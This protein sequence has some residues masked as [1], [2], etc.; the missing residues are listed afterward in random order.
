MGTSFRF[1]H[2]VGYSV[3]LFRYISIYV[4][5][6]IITAKIIRRCRRK[7]IRKTKYHNLCAFV[8]NTAINNDNRKIKNINTISRNIIRV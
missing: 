6:T 7:R 2:T 1:T 5:C 4:V 3:V 8:G